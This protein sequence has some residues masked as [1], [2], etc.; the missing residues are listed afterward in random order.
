MLAVEIMEGLQLFLDVRY[1]HG[2]VWLKQTGRH[3]H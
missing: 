2:S 3:D 1:D